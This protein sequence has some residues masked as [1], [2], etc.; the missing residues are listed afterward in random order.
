M[1]RGVRLVMR[2]TCSGWETRVGTGRREWA[3]EKAQE[4]G[5]QFGST[6]F[7][8][9]LRQAVKEVGGSDTTSRLWVLCER[10]I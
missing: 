2:G 6:V 9:E 5:R 1:R 7:E 8:K 10:R 4:L 3:V